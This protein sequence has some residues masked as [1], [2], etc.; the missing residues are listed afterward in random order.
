MKTCEN[1]KK[2]L[3]LQL[4]EDTIVLYKNK[5]YHISIS[6]AQGNQLVY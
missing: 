6:T 1:I 3:H 5:N 2:D 4:I